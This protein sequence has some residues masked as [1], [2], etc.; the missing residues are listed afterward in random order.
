[1]S[2]AI[3]ILEIGT[4]RLPNTVAQDAIF[5]MSPFG[6]IWLE[7][8]LGEK[9]IKWEEAARYELVLATRLVSDGWML[10]N[11]Y[12]EQAAEQFPHSSPP[13]LNKSVDGS[14]DYQE[15]LESEKGRRKS[16][17]FRLQPKLPEIPEDSILPLT[18]PRTTSFGQHNVQYAGE[19]PL[20]VRAANS[21][22]GNNL[23]DP[24]LPFRDL[25][26]RDN[27]SYGRRPSFIG[28]QTPVSPYLRQIWN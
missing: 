7:W 12:L 15:K 23:I 3:P 24:G 28:L 8:S 6:R 26:I 20:S 9:R 27:L 17:T 2:Q 18:P 16:A 1:M 13:Q 10:Y 19:A 5:Q 25:H 22:H 11:Q 4:S 21:P 14:S